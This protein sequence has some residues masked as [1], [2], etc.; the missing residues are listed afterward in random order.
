MAGLIVLKP[1]RG[2]FFGRAVAGLGVS[3]VAIGLAGAVAPSST[4]VAP[5]A[6]D[7]VGSKLKWKP[8]E[9]K[10]LQQAQCAELIVPRDWGQAGSG[11]YRIAVARLKAAVAPSRG[12]LIFNTGGP[13]GSGLDSLERIVE[14]RFDREAIDSFDIVTFDPRG[15]GDSQPELKG[16]QG[17]V[18]FPVPTTGDVDWAQA[19]LK[20]FDDM[21]AANADCLATNEEH[22]NF[23]GSWQVIRD[24]DALR[25]ALGSDQISF[26]GMSYGSTLGR[27]YAQQFPDRLR[28]LILDG[29]IRP[30]PTIARYSQEHLE[31]DA[32]AI[33]TMLGAFDAGTRRDYRDVMAYLDKNAIDI[34]DVGTLT[35][36]NFAGPMVGQAAYQSSWDD[37]QQLIQEAGMLV[38][39]AKDS[40]TD[41]ERRDQSDDARKPGRSM[42][43][44]QGTRNPLFNFVNCADMHDRPTAQELAVTAAEAARANGTVFGLPV[45]NE[46]YQCAGLPPLGRALPAL[47]GTF[48]L[49]TPPVIV[50]SIGDNKTPWLGAREAANAFTGSAMVTYAGTT[51]VAYG[52]PS[53]DCVDAA[54]TPYLLDLTLPPQSVACPLVRPASLERD[55][56]NR[57][58]GSE[59]DLYPWDEFDWDEID[60]DSID[61]GDIDWDLIDWDLVDWDLIDWDD[62]DWELIEGGL[63]D[64][65]PGD[66]DG[67]EWDWYPADD[68]D[69]DQGDQ[70]GSAD[71]KGSAGEVSAGD[72]GEAGTRQR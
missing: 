63:I 3:L 2:N 10:D 9:R 34:P 33:K 51:H 37:L 1:V 20:G 15:V 5:A 46:G 18:G 56:I 31:S 19:T 53:R 67:D 54:V 71:G 61:W 25:R 12:V 48:R 28:A 62:L 11:T 59:G 43:S 57:G 60:W 36:W 23:V 47:T 64:W 4:A 45:L 58:S 14:N 8:C 26:W 68:G 7:I 50:N 6:P 35:R 40:T 38:R 66:E 69:E 30:D 21:A 42:R 41:P 16:C 27:A 70:Q 65:S 72:G 13:G 24:V 44:D 22:A 39:A 32:T 55:P 52:G 17:E 29:A 49:S